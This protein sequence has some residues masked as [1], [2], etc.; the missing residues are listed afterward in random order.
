M[1]LDGEPWIGRRAFRRT[2]GMV[3]RRDRSDPCK[4]VALVG[5]TVDAPFEGRLAFLRAHIERHRSP[6]GRLMAV[7][8]GGGSA[9]GAIQVRPAAIR[10]LGS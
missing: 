7:F 10:S 8:R 6:H 1:P 4:E 3:R 5:S 2:V 9:I